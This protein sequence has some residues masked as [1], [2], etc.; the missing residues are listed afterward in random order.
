MIDFKKVTCAFGILA[1]TTLALKVKPVAAAYSGSLEVKFSNINSSKGQICMNLFNGQSGFPDGGK[2]AALKI[3]KCTPIV[4]GTAKFMFANLP[5]G[6]YAISAIHDTNG[7]TR[8]NSNF[9]G[10]PTEGIGFSNNT[11]VVNSAPSFSE[12]QF[13]IS[14]SKTDISIKMQYF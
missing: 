7:D 6:N 1:V 5:Y 9:L 11:V 12:S 10:I 13:F 2:G 14:G 8:M 3:A 4:K